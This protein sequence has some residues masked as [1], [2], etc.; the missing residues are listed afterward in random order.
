MW[1]SGSKMSE[2]PA[3][4]LLGNDE[5]LKVDLRMHG[6]S[7]THATCTLY[8]VQERKK[9]L[10]LVVALSTTVVQGVVCR[11]LCVPIPD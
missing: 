2:T 9:S 10:G 6:F 4:V 1:E 7:G 8:F 5:S 11:E 3:C